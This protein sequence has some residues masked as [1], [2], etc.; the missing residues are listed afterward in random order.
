MGQAKEIRVGPISRRDADALIIRQHYSH[1]TV[2][3]AYLA[4]GIFLDGRLRAR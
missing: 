3:N 1:K 2:Q 4:L